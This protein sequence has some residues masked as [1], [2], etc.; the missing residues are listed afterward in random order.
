MT[1]KT[2]IENAGKAVI[3]AFGSKADMAQSD[4]L[5]TLKEEHDEV[6]KLLERL[7][8]SDTARERKSL[9]LQVKKALV[10]HTKAEEKTV[11][12]PVIA[13]LAKDAKIDGAE[14]YFEHALA[15]EMLTKLGKMTKPMS[16]DFSAAAKVLKE[17]VTHHIDEEERNIWSQVKDNFSEDE[18]AAMNRAFLAAKKKVKV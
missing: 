9:V 5:D 3:G 18:R 12:D 1:I 13:L 17:L 14:G 16:P 10:P 8:D 15:S 11:Y 6:K 7:V 4:I 2:T